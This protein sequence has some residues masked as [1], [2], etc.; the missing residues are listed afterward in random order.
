MG[1]VFL[2]SLLAGCGSVGLEDT[3]AV[4]TSTTST[5]VPRTSA[6]VPDT[7]A[8]VREPTVDDLLSDQLVAITVPKGMGAAMVALV[9]ADGAVTSA[10]KGLAPDGAGLT[11]DAVFQV[12][13]LTKMFTAVLVLMLVDDG[14]VDL[15]ATAT[16]YVTR[17]ELPER[18]TVRDLLHHTSGIPNYTDLD[19]PWPTLQSDPERVWSPEEL[20]AL[21]D[22]LPRGEPGALFVYSN[23]NYVVLGVLVEEVTGVPFAAA[24]RDRIL[25]PLE[26]DDTYLA[27]IETGQQP[28]GAY[29]SL[30]GASEPIEFPYTATATFAG[31]SGGLASSVAD[32]HGFLDALFDERLISAELLAEMTAESGYGL[33][34]DRHGTRFGH[35][36]LIL[37]YWTSVLH[38]PDT[39]KTAVVVATNDAATF[40]PSIDAVTYKL[41]E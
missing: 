22:D 3:V 30:N 19:E 26:L 31:A 10:S 7:L 9:D 8:T 25:D 18:V 40:A 29:T 5:T 38:D 37:G 34:I 23:T 36:G 32:L 4:N 6:T 20:V 21:V 24:L 16:D 41:L 14:F 11:L 39:G 12:G 27:G 28:V 13:S 33:G 15:D 1:L 17:V 2:F 35:S